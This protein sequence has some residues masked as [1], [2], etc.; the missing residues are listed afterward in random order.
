MKNGDYSDIMNIEY[1]GDIKSR[2]PYPPMPLGDRA[3]IFGSFAA[4]KGYEDCIAEKKDEVID[5]TN[6]HLIE[7]EEFFD[8]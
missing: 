4:L 7:R 5:Y 3:K 2:S 8:D 6:H 1:P